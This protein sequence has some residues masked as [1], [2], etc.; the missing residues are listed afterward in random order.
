MEKCGD[1]NFSCGDH[2]TCK[3]LKCSC[4]DGWK[5]TFCNTPPPDKCV[6]D[7]DCGNYGIYGTCNK[8][9]GIC[10]CPSGRYGSKCQKFC[11]TNS[12]CGGSSQG[13]CGNEGLCSCVNEW[14]GNNC[15]N[16]PK[17]WKCTE[18]S[19]CNIPNGRCNIKSG[20][21]ICDIY[22]Q[23]M[24]CKDQ[25]NPDPSTK[26][27]LVEYILQ[28]ITQMLTTIDGQ[29]LLAAFILKG[30]LEH[31]ILSGLGSV[32]EKLG[33]VAEKIADDILSR[34]AQE[35]S[36]M[37]VE[38]VINSV[39]IK[40]ISKFAIETLIEFISVVIPVLEFIEDLMQIIQMMGMVIDAQDYLGLNKEMT[41]SY[42]E[43]YKIALYSY[44]NTKMKNGINFPLEFYPIFTKDFNDLFHSK[45]YSYSYTRYF[46][47]YMSSLKINSN[48]DKLIIVGGESNHSSKSIFKWI[49][50]SFII[51]IILFFVML[52]IF[53]YQ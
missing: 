21:C 52:N 43:L 35:F 10:V 51:F 32:K 20:E 24:T 2:G 33:D 26:A 3:D 38:D 1:L 27:G 44:V 49:I 14:S 15:E 29:T 36:D 18:D 8:Y 28:G 37:A 23:G 41:N 25:I 46:R 7:S 48:G 16:P 50:F 34:S 9:L 40:Y 13:L 5:G 47:E 42:L 30:K 53:K 19:Q 39:I 45:K 31:F 4:K 22:H 6:N 11:E 12:D 17:G